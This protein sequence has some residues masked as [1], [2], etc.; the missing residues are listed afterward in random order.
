VCLNRQSVQQ[1]VAGVQVISTPLSQSANDG[2]TGQGQGVFNTLE[3]IGGG[4]GRSFIFGEASVFVKCRK[5]GHVYQSPQDGSLVK[6]S[7]PDLPVI[8]VGEG[9]IGCDPE[10]FT[11]L[12]INIYPQV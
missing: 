3:A 6:P 7:L 10:S 2:F 8:M 5:N 9:H 11:Y 1:V 12:R 4:H